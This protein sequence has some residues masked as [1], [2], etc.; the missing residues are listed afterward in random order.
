MSGVRV[1]GPRTRLW[2]VTTGYLARLTG[3]AAGAFASFTHLVIDECH[4]RSVDADVLCL[5]VRRLLASHPHLPCISPASHLH[6][7]CISPASRSYLGRRESMR[8]HEELSR[9]ERE[10]I[11]HRAE[12]DSAELAEINLV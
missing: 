2:Y 6:L 9:L 3:H 8:S 5:L 10:V 11:D 4:E 7:T 12:F 1:Q